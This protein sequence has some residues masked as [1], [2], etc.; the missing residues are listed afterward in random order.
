M[1]ALQ[2]YTSPIPSRKVH[3]LTIIFFYNLRYEKF[4]NKY[5]EFGILFDPFSYFKQFMPVIFFRTNELFQFG[6]TTA[7][8][9][10]FLQM[11]GFL[12]IPVIAWNAD[13]AGLETVRNIRPTILAIGISFGVTIHNHPSPVIMFL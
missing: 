9:Q 2:Y 13:N 11:A 1:A 3:L 8:S 10:Y 6:R 4:G 7:A 12:G 5:C